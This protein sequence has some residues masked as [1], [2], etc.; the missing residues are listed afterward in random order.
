MR[1]VPKNADT[2]VVA[3]MKF[4]NF[5]PLLEQQCDVNDVAN[6]MVCLME[7]FDHLRSETARRAKR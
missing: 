1:L 7:D 4:V 2:S 3:S 6:Q 5:V